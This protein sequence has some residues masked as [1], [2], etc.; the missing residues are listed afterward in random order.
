MLQKQTKQ[1]QQFGGEQYC[2]TEIDTL[3]PSIH[4]LLKRANKDPLALYQEETD[5]ELETQCTMHV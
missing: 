1:I 4:R 2:Y 3:G 5:I